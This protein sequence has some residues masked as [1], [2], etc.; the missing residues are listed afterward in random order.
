MAPHVRCRINNRLRLSA[1]GALRQRFVNA[2]SMPGRPNYGPGT[3]ITEEPG[4]GTGTAAGHAPDQYSGRSRRSTQ[5][6]G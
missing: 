1:S 5:W 2:I 6:I 4:T 3:R